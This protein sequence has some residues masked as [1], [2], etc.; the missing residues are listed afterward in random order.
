ME[1]AVRRLLAAKEP[2]ELAVVTRSGIAGLWGMLADA[3]ERYPDDPGQ[4]AAL[5]LRRELEGLLEEPEAADDAGADA[6]SVRRDE[7]RTRGNEA[8]GAR[9]WTPSEPPPALGPGS[10]SRG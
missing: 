9:P 7:A 2:S 10:D 6:A 8:G 4:A 1:E 3:I 5:D